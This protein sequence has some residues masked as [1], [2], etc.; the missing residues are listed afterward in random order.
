MAYLQIT[1]EQANNL[2]KDVQ[3]YHR[4]GNALYEKWCSPEYFITHQEEPL[5]DDIWCL[6]GRDWHIE[7]CDAE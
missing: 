2:R 5:A 1:W 6:G 3:L 7:V 4:R